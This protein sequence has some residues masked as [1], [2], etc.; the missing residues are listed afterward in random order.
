LHFL[1]VLLKLKKVSGEI[2][3]DEE[4]HFETDPRFSS[5]ERLN[6][7]RLN[8]TQPGEL[9]P[10]PWRC[11]ACGEVNETLIELSAG[12]QQEYV[13][14]CVV[15]CRPNL[16]KIKIDSASLIISIWNELEYE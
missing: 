3:Q 7:D 1:N 5:D 2:M 9:N 10:R 14:D 16:L 6:H 12:Y 4:D 15:C 8:I 11:A 13:E